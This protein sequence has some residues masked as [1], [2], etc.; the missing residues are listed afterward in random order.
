MSIES[1]SANARQIREMNLGINSMR[2]QYLHILVLLLK[3]DGQ[4]SDILLPCAREAISLLPSLVSNW[5]SV[6]NGLV[7]SENISSSF[8][9]VRRPRMLID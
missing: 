2:F 7:W 6:Y 8:T 3:E 5:G 1:T 9:G 4:S